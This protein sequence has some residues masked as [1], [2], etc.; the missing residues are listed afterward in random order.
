MYWT[1]QKGERLVFRTASFSADRGSILH[2]GIYNREFAAVL[3]A[4]AAAGA[5]TLTVF[6]YFGR[7]VYLYLLFIGLSL[8]LFPLF[9]KF[10]FRERFLEAVFDRAAGTVSLSYPAKGRTVSEAVKMADIRGL[11]IEKRKTTVG[12]PDGVAF[13]EKISLQHGT[14][15]PGFGE[16]HISYL[17]KLALPDESERILYADRDMNRVIAVYDRI[18]SFLGRE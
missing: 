16:E 6:L 2:S 7:T 8:A 15:I 10:L 12:N 3:T 4:S 11:S 5:A 18:N 14:V 1:D 13:V 9:R 17:L